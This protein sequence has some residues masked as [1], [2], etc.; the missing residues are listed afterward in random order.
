MKAGRSPRVFTTPELQRIQAC[1]ENTDMTMSVIAMRFRVSIKKLA[2]LGREL[3]WNNPRPEKTKPSTPNRGILK[4]PKAHR[5]IPAKYDAAQREIVADGDRKRYGSLLEDV[6]WLRR[7]G[8]A[9]N[10]E[11]GEYRVGN[12]IV[13]AED[14]RDKADR[15]RRLAGVAA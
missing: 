2:E 11:K 12:S 3:G 1:I 9:I 5:Y 4:K 7:R 13:S 14:I 15:E 10:C 8:W 6:Q